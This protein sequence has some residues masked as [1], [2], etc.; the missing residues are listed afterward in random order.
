M[1]RL[2]YTDE[3]KERKHMQGVCSSPFDQFLTPGISIAGTKKGALG[4]KSLSI[5]SI[6]GI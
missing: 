2:K 4:G 3:E 6:L 1:L 5:R